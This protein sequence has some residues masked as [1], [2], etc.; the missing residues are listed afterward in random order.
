MIQF[1][2]FYTFYR[3]QSFQVI[4]MHFYLLTEIYRQPTEI[5]HFNWLPTK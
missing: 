5:E 4:N 2:N 1:Y 3:D